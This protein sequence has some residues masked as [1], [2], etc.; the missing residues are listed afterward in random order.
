MVPGHPFLQVHDGQHAALG[1]GTT[2]QRGVPPF[3]DAGIPAG[4]VFPQ[5]AKH[6]AL[7][8]ERSDRRPGALVAGSACMTNE[9]WLSN[10]LLNSHLPYIEQQL[11][12]E[13]TTGQYAT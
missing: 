2:A 10:P 6:V 11:T 8:F 1:V 4:R 3:L 7:Q 5:P 13:V 12:Q 9:V